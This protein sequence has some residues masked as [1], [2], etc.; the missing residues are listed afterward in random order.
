MSLVHKIDNM[1]EPLRDLA[2]NFGQPVWALAARL[3]IAN[4]FFK[5][6][7]TRYH[8]WTHGNFANQISLFTT[9]HPVPGIPPDIAAYMALGGEMILPVL[10]A[11]GLFGRFA[12]GGLLVMTVVLEYAIEHFAWQFHDHILWAFLTAA[13]LVYGP[14]MI[15]LDSLILRVIRKSR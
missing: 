13:L 6:G 4:V 8:D 2:E 12:A 14:G 5:S 10:L 1:I 15:S 9:E 7:M 11:I 3:Y